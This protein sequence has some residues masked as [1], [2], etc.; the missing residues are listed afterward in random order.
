MK[1][2][3]FIE[4]LLFLNSLEQLA[5]FHAESRENILFGMDC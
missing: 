2:T 3:S 1:I 5:S 4:S